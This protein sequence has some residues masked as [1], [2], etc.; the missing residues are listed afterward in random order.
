MDQSSEFLSCSIKD[1]L[2]DGSILIAYS[3][4]RAAA[5]RSASLGISTASDR[6]APVKLARFRFF[7]TAKFALI[8]SALV[9][10]ASLNST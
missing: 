1:H 7:A 4:M 3:G 10:F 8:S 9:R 2:A 6:F 5:E